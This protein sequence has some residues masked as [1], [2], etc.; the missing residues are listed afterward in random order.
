MTIMGCWPLPTL[1][2]G[3]PR[4]WHTLSVVLSVVGVGS[5]WVHMGLVG[6]VGDIAESGNLAK[7][8]YA[9]EIGG[10]AEQKVCA[11]GIAWLG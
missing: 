7:G 2:L 1:V 5:H 6:M 4:V 9:C 3:L 11:V 10:H 8:A